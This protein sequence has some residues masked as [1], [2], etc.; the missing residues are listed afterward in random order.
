MRNYL[1]INHGEQRVF[2][3]FEIII[4][5]SALLYLNTYAM[6]LRTLEIFY[7][8]DFICQNLTYKDFILQQTVPTQKG[9]C[10]KKKIIISNPTRGLL[11]YQRLKHT[12]GLG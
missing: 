11:F 7:F 12:L 5:M 6:G 10:A 9:H 2:F 1:Y 3:K 8:I 4:S